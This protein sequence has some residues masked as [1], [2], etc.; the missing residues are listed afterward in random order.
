MDSL[1]DRL[2]CMRIG[3]LTHSTCI[4]TLS[5]NKPQHAE[6]TTMNAS[7]SVM[8]TAHTY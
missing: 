5:N 6:S 1:H 3:S 8:Q 7:A 4:I 2:S